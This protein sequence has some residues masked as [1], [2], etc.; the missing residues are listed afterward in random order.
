MRRQLGVLAC[1]ALLLLPLAT[2]ATAQTDSDTRPASS[3][4]LGDTGLWFVPSAEVLG[5]RK[6]AVSGQRGNW[7]REQGFTDI[8]SYAGTFAVGLKDRVEIF[9]SFQFLTR[10]DR[11]VRPLFR[12][13]FP[14]VGGLV[15]E[16]P[17][18]NDTF[19]GNQ[20]G[21]FVVGAKFNLLS[22][23]RLDA[24]AL[25]IRGFVKLPTGDDE[26]GVSTG[27]FDGAF[28][29]VAT[30]AYDTIE[31]SGYGGFIVR[32]DPDGID[33]S[34]GFRYGVGLSGPVNGRLRFFGEING[35]SHISSSIAI[36]ALE[37][38]NLVNS[39]LRSPLDITLGLEWNSPRG[40][41]IGG[42]LNVAGVHTGR[43][44]TGSETPSGDRLGLLVRI[45][46]H[47]GVNV[48]T[49]PPPP[50]PEPDAP[51]RPPTVSVQCDPCEVLVG[52]ESRLR[53]DASDPDGD[54]LT[55][56]W[57]AP[58]GSF[59]DPQNRATQRW[60]APNQAGPVPISVTV[61]DG[62]GGSATDSTTVRVT[63]PPPP[64]QREYVFEDV[65]FDFDRYSLRPG[66][67]RVLDEV[68][69]ALQDDPNLRIHIEGHTCNIGTAEYNLALGDRRSNAVQEYLASRGVGGRVT[70]VSYGEERP[71]H[72]NSREETRRLNRRAALVVT[73]Q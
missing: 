19:S 69:A 39:P 20:L 37:D 48:Y 72:D 10:I 45:G 11:D 6:F 51:N 64:P 14:N 68:V 66:A 36:T 3:T 28:D 73:V 62:R 30:R 63:A 4:F 58:A 44:R 24:A 61:T 35:E 54:T 60:Q 57:N 67:T 7:D 16:Y 65:H 13:D 25:A 32:G 31:V 71:Q 55:Y 42:G 49:P 70:T 26:S 8:Q 59:Q 38:F 17:L 41:S 50:P 18:V 27:K 9:G 23:E 15:N 34:N 46:Y 21:D 5:D 47:P 53:A 22:Q 29:V 12:S 52:E 1:A 56:A 33:I 2:P 43:S 40:I